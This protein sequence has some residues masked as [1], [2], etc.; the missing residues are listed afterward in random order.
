LNIWRRSLS[1]RESFTTGSATARDTANDLTAFLSD[2][3][4]TSLV[5]VIPGLC[6]LLLD[7]PDAGGLSTD[8]PAL[9][10][11]LSRA[12]VEA[13]PAHSQ[14]IGPIPA[15]LFRISGP[16]DGALAV[17]PFTW[18]ADSGERA[19]GFI[20]RA[21]PVH[22][23]ADQA[24]LRLFDSTTFSLT[25]PEARALVEAFN[26]HYAR[27][28]W[29]L[30]APHP[31]RWYLTLSEAP[32]ITTVAPSQLAGRDIREGMPQGKAGASW[33]AFL[34]EVQMLFHGHPV[35]RAREQRG[36]PMVNSIWPWGGGYLP[37]GVATAVTRVFAGQ[38]LLRGLAQLAG[39]PCRD[40]P[41]TASDLMEPAACGLQLVLLDP[42]ERAWRYGEVESWGR[43]VLQLETTW[44]NPLLDMLQ[45]GRLE[46]L[47]LYPLE[48]RRYMINRWRLRC[49]W[50]P[51]R[52][53]SWHCRHAFSAAR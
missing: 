30:H 23:R 5:L 3:S 32:E 12:R 50:K 28:G 17:A 39:V 25:A 13:R 40:V 6:G 22:L 48:A 20:M 7:V 52:S 47:Y 18:L 49:F 19:A 38:P 34:N 11:L 26:D 10:R 29:R 16:D 2:A 14:E 15:G 35:N 46:H 4:S 33:H 27:Q 53:L 24:C 43:A 1:R 8:L 9:E 45:Q 44:F 37:A 36:E 41:A 42:L 31:Q 51:V 21:D